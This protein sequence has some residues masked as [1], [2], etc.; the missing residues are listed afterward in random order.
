MPTK[1]KKVFCLFFLRSC[2][3]FKDKNSKRSRRTVGISVADPGMF[4][5]DPDFTRPGSRIQKQQQKR[6][7]KKKFVITFYVATN[8]TKLKNN[9]SF[10][11]LKKKIWANF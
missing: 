9:F 1:N 6:G 10:E 7:V 4:I 3:I 2:I 5:S 11:V 8:F